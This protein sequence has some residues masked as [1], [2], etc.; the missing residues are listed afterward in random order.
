MT[1]DCN[2]YSNLHFLQYL[3][4]G[5][6]PTVAGG[7]CGNSYLWWLMYAVPAR[8]LQYVAAPII[9]VIIYGNVQHLLHIQYL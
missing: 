2:I 9:S 7:G 8:R 1:V 5:S 3:W 6:V 4:S